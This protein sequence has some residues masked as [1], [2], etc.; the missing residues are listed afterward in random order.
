MII[1]MNAAGLE[2]AGEFDQLGDILRQIGSGG[3]EFP[4]QMWQRRPAR[5]EAFSRVMVS[6]LSG[7]LHRTDVLP[8]SLLAPTET[9]KRQAATFRSKCEVAVSLGCPA[10]AVGLD[11]WAHIPYDTALPIFLD[12]ARHCS[13]IAAEFGLNLNLEFISADVA[14]K[15]GPTPEIPFCRSLVHAC[16]LIAMIERQNA[17][18]LLDIVHW[19]ADGAT[20][21]PSQL[22]P[23]LGM[24]HLADSPR[25]LG[26]ICSDNDRLLPYDGVLPVSNFLSQLK[27]AHFKG[28]IIIETFNPKIC[29]DKPKIADVLARVKFEATQ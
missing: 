1:G 9:W 27:I 12:R 2:W 11:A 20:R 13:D 26:S 3:V 25:K 8:E 18:L 19:H 4:V 23:I 28:P 6:S 24:V 15:N 14:T 5:P 22:V 10:F 17:R 7:L 16:E 29:S 21:E